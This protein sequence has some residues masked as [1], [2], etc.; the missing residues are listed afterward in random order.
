MEIFKDGMRP[1]Y[2]MSIQDVMREL[3]NGLVPTLD[4][5]W[6]QTVVEIISGCIERDLQRR[7]NVKNV[8]NAWLNSVAGASEVLL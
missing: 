6:G 7:W 8:F 1:F 4:E 2:P 3:P 5:K